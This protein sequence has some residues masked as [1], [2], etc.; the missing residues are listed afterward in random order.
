M[1]SGGLCAPPRHLRDRPVGRGSPTRRARR[2]PLRASNRGMCASARRASARRHQHARAAPHAPDRTRPDPIRA[3]TWL[4]ERFTAPGRDL[5]SRRRAPSRRTRRPDRGRRHHNAALVA[6]RLPGAPAR[7]AR[8]LAEQLRAV[9]AAR[10]CGPG[11]PRDETTGLMLS[12]GFD[13][14]AVAG[15][16]ASETRRRASCGPIPRVSRR[17]GDRRVR[18]RARS[19]R[20]AGP[21]QPPAPR[22]SPPGSFALP[23]NTSAIGGFRPAARAICSSARCSSARRRTASRGMLD[24]QGGDELFGFSPYLIADRV[25]RGQLRTALRLLAQ[26]PDHAGRPPRHVLRHLVR[27]YAIRPLLPVR[28]RASAA[29]SAAT[30][31]ATC[32]PG[33][34]ATGW[35]CSCRATLAWPGSR[36]TTDRCGGA[37]SPTA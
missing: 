18:A 36:P 30:P 5:R 22:S 19:R 21:A 28:P 24:G 12:G 17:P 32:R 20:G 35:T 34:A 1:G 8:A 15:V 27:E 14:S 31:H 2:R 26:L 13:S 6:A 7:A 4:G 33:C 29:D 9:A 11:R 3:I 23:W 16:A 10:R 37:I 25:R